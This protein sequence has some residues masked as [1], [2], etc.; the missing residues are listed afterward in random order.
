MTDCSL[1][2]KRASTPFGISPA[3]HPCQTL[4]RQ[5]LCTCSC[6]I[7]SATCPPVL[8]LLS[9]PTQEPLCTYPLHPSPPVLL[10][11]HFPLLIHPPPPP[12]PLSVLPPPPKTPVCCPANF[13]QFSCGRPLR[14]ASR[15]L[16]QIN[17]RRVAYC[18]ASAIAALLPPVKPAT[19]VSGAGWPCQLLLQAAAGPL[20]SWAPQQPVGL[21]APPSEAHVVA[22]AS[23]VVDAAGQGLGDRPLVPHLVLA[24]AAPHVHLHAR[25]CTAGW[26]GVAAERG[27]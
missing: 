8:P 16:W 15:T 1:L 25:A 10:P 24:R 18:K 14:V 9:L 5:Q 2:L 27:S 4:F 3:N 6:L 20:P 19:A 23:R 12:S 17:D 13:V 26:G 11:P 7:L 22:P 21:P